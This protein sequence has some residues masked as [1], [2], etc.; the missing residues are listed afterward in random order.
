MG[1][2]FAAQFAAKQMIA[3]GT[4]CGSIV[5]VASIA[6]HMAIRSQLS[7]AYCGSKGAVKAMTPAIAKELAPHVRISISEQMNHTV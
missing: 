3:N 6:S 2:F 1:I 4:K 5:L 7:S